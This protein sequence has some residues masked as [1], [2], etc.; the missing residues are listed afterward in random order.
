VLFRVTGLDLELNDL[1]G[2]SFH[3]F[4]QIE[5]VDDG[6]W[7]LDFLDTNIYRRAHEYAND[8]L[9]RMTER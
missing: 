8:V 1:T 9:R 5:L 6:V 3:M 4:H 7:P 2:E